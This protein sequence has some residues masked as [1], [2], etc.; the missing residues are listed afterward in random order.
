MGGETPAWRAIRIRFSPELIGLEVIATGS[1]YA[2][3]EF[4]VVYELFDL[5]TTDVID[6]PAEAR[7]G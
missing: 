1:R 3:G 2:E 7:G 4:H 5:G 6:I